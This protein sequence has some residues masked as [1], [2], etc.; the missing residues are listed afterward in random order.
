MKSALL[1]SLFIL[2]LVN[3]VLSQTCTDCEKRNII[4]YD[5]D[6]KIPEPDYK[7]IPAGQQIAAYAE[8]SNL[9]YIAGGIRNYVWKDPTTDCLRKLD[10]AFFTQPDSINNT[11]RTGLGHPNLPPSSGSTAMGDYIIYG[12]V[13]GDNGSYTLQLKLETAKSRELVKS[14]SVNF[15]AGFKPLDVGLNAASAFGPLYT[16]MLDFE[17][18]KRDEGEPYA[19]KA[20]VEIVPEKK[21]LKKQETC[22]VDIT[23][24][25]CDNQP[26]KSRTVKLEAQNGS[27]DNSTVT[28]DDQGKAKA[29]FTA[30]D[31]DGVATLSAYFSYTKPT[32]WA[33]VSEG[34]NVLIQINKS[35]WDVAC[36]Y[37]ITESVD[38]VQ[39]IGNA[40]RTEGTSERGSRGYVTAVIDEQSDTYGHYTTKSVVSETIGGSS[41]ENTSE[42]TQGSASDANTSMY[43][44]KVS[45]SQCNSSTMKSKQSI[46]ISI[47]KTSRHFAFTSNF[48][49]MSGG[50]ASNSLAIYCNKDNCQTTTSSDVVDC[51]YSAVGDGMHTYDAPGSDQDTSYTTTTNNSLAGMTTTHK[52]HQVS[53]HGDSSY[54]FTYDDDGTVVQEQEGS[55]RR[56]TSSKEHITMKIATPST[57]DIKNAQQK[58]GLHRNTIYY[59]DKAKIL[60]YSLSRD[61]KIMLVVYDATGRNIKTLVNSVQH[62]G[63]YAVNLTDAG[64][65]A[66]LYFCKF[67]TDGINVTKKLVMLP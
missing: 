44:N 46:N 16:T 40:T 57:T 39:T 3:D 4:V 13:S 6:I 52:I 18:K 31:N 36:T 1:S 7:N 51:S 9:Y 8:W 55:Y 28:T 34:G 45:A 67:A 56:V 25:D 41:F 14:N 19:I 2:F 42:H 24:T 60:H 32:G 20:K 29:E 59:F 48:E 22:K 11:I 15:S 33:T 47:G 12:V 23:V 49:D 58:N 27:F 10:C 64:M 65:S 35:Y 43:S 50:G 5:N 63:N 37:T 54:T 53:T 30:G 38:F 61:G 17:K 66:G 62:A 26:L 21:N